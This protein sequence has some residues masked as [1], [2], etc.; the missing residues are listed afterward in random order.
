MRRPTTHFVRVLSR[1]MSKNIL[2][3]LNYIQ[4]KLLIVTQEQYHTTKVIGHSVKSLQDVPMRRPATYFFNSFKQ[5]YF[6]K[7]PQNIESWTIKAGFIYLYII[8]RNIV[9]AHSLK[10]L[11]DVPM[12]RPA[13]HFVRVLSRLMSKNILKALNYI[14]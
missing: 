13:T 4:Y 10:S 8:S 3:A 12:T 6:S 7:S 14:Q 9:I 5:N 2:K 11:K 1:L